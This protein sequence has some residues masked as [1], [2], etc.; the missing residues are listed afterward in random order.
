MSVLDNFGRWK[1]FLN[2]RM[3]QGKNLGIDEQTMTDFAAEVGDY[4]AKNVDPQNE[5]E[6]LL[7]DL[8]EV[9]NEEE[10]R[11]MAHLMMKL[12]QKQ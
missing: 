4:L 8:W 12:V 10:Q 6:R 9:G 3:Q 11:T 1:D 7:K 2:E 5:E